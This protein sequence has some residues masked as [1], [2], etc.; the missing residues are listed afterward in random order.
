[1]FLA[2]AVDLFTELP[3]RL[4]FSE[5]HGSNLDA[6]DPGPRVYEGGCWANPPPMQGCMVA[7]V[8]RFR[9]NRLQV[10]TAELPENLSCVV[11]CVAGDALHRTKRSSGLA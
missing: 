7:R 10:V 3:R 6:S 2:D 9:G 11:F 5:T 8:A 1:M 4:T